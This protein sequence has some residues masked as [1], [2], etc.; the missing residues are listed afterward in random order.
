MLHQWNAFLPFNHNDRQV[1]QY[2]IV[3]YA[4]N[5]ETL[6][7]LGGHSAFQWVSA[8]L[9]LIDMLLYLYKADFIQRFLNQNEKKLARSFNCTFRYIDDVLSLNTFDELVD[10]IYPI[11]FEIKDTTDTD[12]SAAYLDLHPA[13]DSDCRLRLNLY[14]KRLENLCKSIDYIMPANCLEIDILFIW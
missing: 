14:N 2:F 5:T 13:I 8:V 6:V 7:I 1:L 9:L 11:E 4:T 12:M 10:P 3:N